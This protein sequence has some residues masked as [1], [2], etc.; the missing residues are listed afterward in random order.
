[1]QSSQEQMAQPSSFQMSGCQTESEGFAPLLESLGLRFTTAGHY[2]Q[3]GSITQ[4]QGWILHLSVIKSQLPALLRVVIPELAT[5]NVPF[6]I[7]KDVENASN[8][9]D[10]CLGYQNLGKLVC[11][12]PGTDL[13]ASQLA[14]TLIALTNSYRGPRIPTDFHLGSIVY[15]RYGSFNPVI[16]IDVK[17]GQQKCIYN[18]KGDLVPDPYNIPFSLPKGIVWPFGSIRPFTTQEAG[19]LLNG[20]YYRLSTLK[21]DP[22]GSV[23]KA[24]YFKRPWRIAS[25]V[26]KQAQYAMLADDASREMSD[27]L[28]WQS[29]LYKDLNE[30]IPMPKII[31]FFEEQGSTYLAMEFIK[32]ITLHSWLDRIYSERSWLDL[33]TSS[34][35]KIV[36]RLIA[37][38]RLIA[39]IHDLDYVHRDITPENFMVDKHDR[40]YLIDLELAW[41]VRS[42]YPNPAFGVGTPGFI[43]PEQMNGS[44]P[45]VKE[46]IYALG[47]LMLLFFTNLLPLKWKSRNP[48]MLRR[49]LPDFIDDEQ[50]CD[51]ICDCIQPS[52]N[53]RPE[54]SVLTNI[55]EYFRKKL[56]VSSASAHGSTVFR[57]LSPDAIHS[58]INAALY[59]LTNPIL[60]SKKGR[61]LSRTEYKNN[62]MLNEQVGLEVR[63]GWHTGVAGPLWLVARAKKAGYDISRCNAV[64]EI[65]WNYLRHEYLSQPATVRP[66]LFSGGAGIALA[67]VEGL[68]NSLIRFDGGIQ[69]R[70]SALFLADP[71]DLS[72]AEGVA[73]QGLV[74]LRALPWLEKSTS[75]QALLVYIE[76]LLMSQTKQ[77]YWKTASGAQ[78]IDLYG[79]NTG[80]ILFLLAYLQI[81]TNAQAL[82]SLQKAIRWLLLSAVDRYGLFKPNIIRSSADRIGAILCLIRSYRLFRDEKL[83]SVAEN[84]LRLIAPRIVSSNFSLQSGLCAFGHLYVEANCVFESD[85]WFLRSSWIAKLLSLTFQESSQHF[86]YWITEQNTVITADLFQGTAG[87]IDFLLRYHSPNKISHPFWPNEQSAECPR[88]DN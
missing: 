82:F 72:L 10:G 25:C 16:A 36:D 77:G 40:L 59:G 41:S 73:G 71:Q 51:L 48:E 15:T 22:K 39:S 80:I 74:L 37:I 61:W 70:L 84:N 12:Y 44:V 33:P 18:N 85:E 67:I 63:P 30:K 42:Q 1:M 47:S 19:L 54:L 60:L 50:I 31:D 21:N 3:V 34:R 87:I 4:T 35:L 76:K 53:K 86:G 62:Q 52:P 79:G 26:I 65:N 28:K 13:L 64:Y 49:S 75:E 88:P 78:E 17:N 32:G 45:T 38:V 11:I 69:D 23:I 57:Q 83:K 9:L 27:R 2:W 81:Y 43:S 20:K 56:H 46:D 14:A 7:V 6:K 66:G 24:I 5:H 68:S 29:T 55:L 58:I 8:L